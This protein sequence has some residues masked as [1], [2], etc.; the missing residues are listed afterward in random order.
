MYSALR[1]PADVA[2]APDAEAQM[3]WTCRSLAT[4]GVSLDMKAPTNVAY[5]F[6]KPVS[7]ID[8]YNPVPT[9]TLPAG[10]WATAASFE[11]PPGGRSKCGDSTTTT[12]R[13][14]VAPVVPS[15]PRRTSVLSCFAP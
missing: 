2:A 12:P 15:I 8:P 7:A 14:P 11:K 5:A 9:T 13:P 3:A 4:T 10:Q 6:T 1:R